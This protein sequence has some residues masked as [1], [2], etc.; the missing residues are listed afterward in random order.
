MYIHMS[1]LLSDQLTHLL[2]SVDH[3]GVQIPVALLA[4]YTTVEPLK[5]KG[6]GGRGAQCI[7]ILHVKEISTCKA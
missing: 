5:G 6:R 1:A 7:Y 2:H 3:Y 4:P